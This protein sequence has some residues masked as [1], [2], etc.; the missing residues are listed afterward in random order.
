MWWRRLGIRGVSAPDPELVNAVQPVLVLGDH[1]GHASHVRRR[2]GIGSFGIAAPVAANYSAYVLHCRAPGGLI[3]HHFSL[4]QPAS[5]APTD[6]PHYVW[7]MG[8]VPHT[9]PSGAVFSI[10][11]DLPCRSKAGTR[12]DA[13]A[14]VPTV[15]PG[16][17]AYFAA[18]TSIAAS[19]WAGRGSSIFPVNAW[20]A[21][22]RAFYI[23]SAG[24]KQG[25]YGFCR[26]TELDVPPALL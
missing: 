11:P 22:G 19:P 13:A 21:P 24:T 9:N 16:D 6:F 7:T 5:I 10:D 23:E 15:H 8:V 14:Y 1:S 12:T 20:L 4:Y 2:E 3:L 17:L 25:L 18:P 26:F